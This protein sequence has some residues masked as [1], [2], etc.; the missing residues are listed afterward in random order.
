[1]K[2][3][4]GATVEVEAVDL[5]AGEKTVEFTFVK[6]VKAEELTGVWTVDGITYDLT[7]ANNLEAFEEAATQ[8]DTYKALT[9]LGIENLDA[10]NAAAYFADKEA[11]LEKLAKEDKAL[12]K[13]AVQAFVDKVNA[14]S[15]SAEEEAAIV[16]AVI[17]AEGNNVKLKAALANKA[18]TKVNN[19]WIENVAGTP[20]ID[21]YAKELAEGSL[22]A[23]T[24][25]IEDVQTIIN[26]VNEAVIAAEI[27]AVKPTESVDKA[28][29]AKLKTLIETYAPVD[30]DGEYVTDDN[31]TALEDIEIQSAVAD[32][33]AATTASKFKSTVEALAPLANAKTAGT[34]DLK[35]YVDANGK[36]YIEKIKKLN[37]DGSEVEVDGVEG[38][39]NTAAEVQ[40]VIEAVN[41]E[42]ADAAAVKEFTD[43]EAALKNTTTA[44]DKAKVVDAL[45]ALGLKQV[46]S[47]KANVEAY[48][49]EGVVSAITTASQTVTAD[50]SGGESKPNP[51]KAKTAKVT[52]QGEID[53][54]NIEVI[55]A[56]DKDGIIAAL[57]VLELKNV[58]AANAQAYATAEAKSFVTNA[59][60]AQ[61]FVDN[62]NKAVNIEAAVKA[63]NEAKTA[64]EVKTALDTLANEGKVEGYL[65]VTSAD[66]IFIAEQ[67]LDARDE[68]EAAGDAKAKEF[69]DETAVGEAVTAATTARTNAIKYVNSLKIDDTLT[70]IA[71]GLLLVGHEALTGTAGTTEDGESITGGSPTA[72][73]TNIADAF[74]TSLGF[75]EDGVIKPQFRSIAEIRTAITNAVK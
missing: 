36:A 18:F 50:S 33:L 4:K 1:M 42:I 39:V 5:S 23:K 60:T 9:D 45:K 74:I 46:S 30:E 17:D 31:K 8:L 72:N 21:G 15:I 65:N 20:V 37:A 53:E 58:V 11:F 75:D 41:K 22:D 67:V 7:L 13:E 24:S 26:K 3:S 47:N 62:V 14:D 43:L 63:I 57:N 69:A 44:A 64:T 10:D 32:V 29:L 49:S 56:A 6:P 12:T 59:T 51:E 28:K 55:K 40:T 35:E 61:N 48:V 52:I 38:K 68:I 27:E 54:A 66:R 25:T 34:I 70:E 73:D 16:K 2:N 71:D 19:D